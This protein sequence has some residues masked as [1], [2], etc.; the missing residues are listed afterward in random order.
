MNIKG[1]RRR[2]KRAEIKNERENERAG[3]IRLG[4]QVVRIVFTQ[5]RV[6]P[7]LCTSASVHEAEKVIKE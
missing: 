7:L 5:L 4:D 3:W 2:G 6:A 1:R